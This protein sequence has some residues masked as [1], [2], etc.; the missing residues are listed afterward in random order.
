VTGTGATTDLT[1]LAGQL[2]SQASASSTITLDGSVLPVAVVAAI[3]AAFTLPAGTSLTVTGVKDTDVPT[4]SGNQL[5]ISAGT[6]AVLSLENVPIGLTFA[7][8]GNALEVIVSATMAASWTFSDSFAGLD[9]FPFADLTVTDAR[10]VFTTA[11]QPAYPWPADPSSTIELATGLNF[12]SDVGLGGFSLIASLLGSVIGS[13]SFK[14]YGPFAPTAGQKLPVGTLLAP[15]GD[16]PFA[17]GTAPNQL[18]LTNPAVAVQIGTADQDTNPIQDVDLLLQGEFQKDLLVALSV[19]VNGTSYTVSTTPLPNQSSITSLIESLPGG[20]G[21]TDYI[22]SELST[23]FSEIGLDNFTMVVDTTPAVTFLGLS[24]STLKP[25][26]VVTDVLV[27]EGLNLVVEVVEPAGL[28]WTRVLIEAQAKFLP[29]IFTGEFDFTVGLDKLTSWEVSTVSGSY[30][31]AVNLGDI[32]GGLLGSQSSVP[33]ALRDISFSNF[34]VSAVRDSPGGPF[35]YTCY[36]STDVAFPLLDTELTAQLNLTFTKTA[37]SY[38]IMLTGALAIGAEAFA[39]E[40]DLGTSGSQLSATWASTGAP[41]E[42]GDIA[43][44]LGWT[45]M[46]ALPGNLD[47]ALTGAGFSYD[48]DAAS[49]VLTATSKNYGQLVFATEQLNSQRAYLFDLSVPLNVKLSDIPVAGQQIPPSVDVGIKTLEVAYASATFPASAVSQ[50]DTTLQSI[51]AQP[52]GY[53]ELD[54]GMM[55]VATLQLG[56]EQQTLTLPLGASDSEQRSVAALPSAAAPAVITQDGQPVQVAAA[57]APTQAAG[58]WFD[59]GKTFGPLQIER[60]GIEYQNS[61]LIFALDANIS[62]GPMALSLQGLGVGSPITAFSP[63]FSLTGLGMSYNK[64]PLEILGAIL[65]VPDAQLAQDVEFQ[66]DGVLVLK[67][68]D[69][70]LSAIGSYAQLRSG[71]PSLFVFAQLEA[72]LGGPPAFFVTGLMAGFGFNRTLEIPAQDEV[73]GFPLLVLAAPPKPGESAAQDPTQVLGVLEGTKALN[74][75]TK[76][77]ITPKAGEYWLAAGL[78]FTSFELVS[79]KALLVAEFGQELNIALLG[80]STMQ[81]PLPAASS[82]TYAYVEMMIRVVVQPTQ[83]YFAATAI[84][85]NSSYV[86]TPDCH[87]T[88]GFAFYL[89][90]GDNPNAGQFVITLGGYHPAFQIPSYFPQVPRLGFNW[91][92]S[93]VVSIKGNAYFALTSSCIMAGGGLEVLFHDG[94]L[95]AWFTAQADFLLSW[96]PFFYTAEIAVSIGVSYRLNLLFCHKTITASLGADLNLWGPPTGGV[97][98]IDLVV[99]SFSVDFGSDRA[100][101]DK[102]PLGWSDFTALLPDTGTVCSIAITD[103]LFKTQDSSES[104]SGKTWIVRAK[105]FAFQTRSAIPASQ[106]DYAGNTVVKSDIAQGGIAIKP[107]NLT[108]VTS[109]HTLTICQGSSNEPIDT[110]AWSLVGLPQ[111]VPASLWSS[112]PVPFTQIPAQPSAEVIAGQLCGFTVTA[113]VPQPGDSRGVVAV[114]L[115]MEEYITPAGQAP[116][117]GTAA[118]SPDYVASFNQHTVG[119][120]EQTMAAAAQQSRTALFAVLTG[121]GLFSGVNGDLS[122]LAAGADHLFSDSPLQQN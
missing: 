2:R 109:T 105:E 67:A 122:Q 15:L 111:T 66:F 95:R 38:S 64:P 44:A 6:A 20:A 102:Q 58:K 90:F 45:D 118:P 21:F 30:A 93:D 88:G 40:L 25:W 77:W 13:N 10:F 80:L 24:V 71:L 16:S 84:L 4:P 52:L 115:L 36:G 8:S 78:E 3:A 34:G 92:V 33:A 68:E 121:S 81:L 48:F 104:T 62:F 12:L 87:L 7:V 17:I 29:S 51:G 73:A 98:K 14:F 53:S 82:E 63:V 59:V 26:P 69:F 50:L 43:T 96:H 106:L 83:G 117:S 70:S 119:L 23:V 99:V 56:S 28:D 72:T 55:F 32:V 42:F 85:S 91:A 11:E 54:A 18:S 19:P 107:M 116:L 27:L 47:L 100:G 103:G 75:I 9:T 97:V 41:L 108:D 37:T 79:T 112:P 120:I 61:V 49:L 5:T 86:L 31:G 114:Q 46:P 110:S 89:W 22:P 60:I 1:T 39:L 57:T 76:A 94:D 113:P 101:Q 35:S 65:R 74:G